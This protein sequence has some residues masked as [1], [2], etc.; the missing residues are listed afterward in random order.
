MEMQ[1]ELQFQIFWMC[2][3]IV[4]S[5]K[6]IQQKC[7]G[8]AMQILYKETCKSKFLDLLQD[9]GVFMG[10]TPVLGSPRPLEMVG[11]ITCIMVCYIFTLSL[12]LLE[13]PYI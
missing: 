6:E 2:F 1:R 9:S 7:K 3:K 4:V 13:Q 8:N 12:K 11:H 10:N 5:S